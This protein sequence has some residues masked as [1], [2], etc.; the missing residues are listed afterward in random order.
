MDSYKSKQELSI[1]LLFGNIVNIT[2]TF[3]VCICVCERERE[4]KKNK[5]I[6][7]QIMNKTKYGK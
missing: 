3:C 6:G 1:I 7:V 2:R 4:L 5:V